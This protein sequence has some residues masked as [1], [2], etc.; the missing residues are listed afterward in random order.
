MLLNGSVLNRAVLNGTIGS[1]ITT[2]VAGI[3]VASAIGGSYQY[4]T[5]FVPATGAA[6]LAVPGGCNVS[7]GTTAYPSA[8][9]GSPVIGGQ[10]VFWSSRVAPQGSVSAGFIGGVYAY[11]AFPAFAFP[12]AIIGT[13]IIG[14]PHAYGTTRYVPGFWDPSVGGVS[15]GSNI[16]GFGANAVTG[17]GSSQA[18]VP[19][20]GSASVTAGSSSL[21]IPGF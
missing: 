8:P 2:V 21:A 7:L 12:S 18:G 5:A 9:I 17:S 6:S 3:V 19:G 11:I 13:P 10:A 14:G 1:S 15:N 20:C 16:P 4:G